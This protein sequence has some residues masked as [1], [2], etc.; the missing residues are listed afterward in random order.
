MARVLVMSYSDLAR[1]PRVDRQIGFLRSHHRI[2]A[3][4]LAPPQHP[5]DEFIDISPTPRPLPGRALGLAL[6]LTRRYHASFWTAPSHI[7]VLERLQH[8]RPDVVVANDIATLPI[9]LRLGASVVFDAH[10]H[11]PSQSPER[12]GWRALYAPRIRWLC[13]RYIPRASV[14]LTVSE[15]LADLY[16]RETG[17]R[18]RVVTNAPQYADLVPTPVHDPVRIVH[19]GGA[20]P[21]RGLEEMVRAASLLDERFTSDFMLVENTPG[22]REKLIR[23]AD[24]NP[25]IRFPEPQPMHT[26]VQVANDYDIGV[27]LLPPVSPQRRYALPNKLF[28]FIQARLAVAIGPS[29]EMARIVRSYGCGVVTDDFEPQTFAAALNGLDSAA[30]TAFKGASHAAA[31]ELCAE[32]NEAIVVGAVQDALS[33]AG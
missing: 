17:V 11:A 26:L 24:G 3:A 2:V 10:E 30:I 8:V 33:H 21:G 32:R 16:A 5:V 7:A 15:M 25:R 9:A 19:H 28:E 22:F 1:D 31:R 27:F 6:L 4:G 18:A 23:L 13:Q 20:Q 12:W 14:M 29:P